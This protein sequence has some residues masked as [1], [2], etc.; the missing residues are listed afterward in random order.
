[1][2]TAMSCNRVLYNDGV[3]FC[4]LVLVARK[5]NLKNCPE[6]SFLPTFKLSPIACPAEVPGEVTI[7]KVW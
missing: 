1:M 6:S 4:Q 5:F 3:C 2:T 7:S